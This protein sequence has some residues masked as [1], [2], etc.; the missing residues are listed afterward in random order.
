MCEL[1]KFRTGHCS[2]AI[3]NQIKWIDFVLAQ[4]SAAAPPSPQ[5]AAVAH[6]VLRFYLNQPNY[7]IS[8]L[9]YSSGWYSKYISVALCC[10]RAPFAVQY[11][12]CANLIWWHFICYARSLISFVYFLFLVFV[13][14]P[15]HAHMRSTLCLLYTLARPSIDTHAE[16]SFRWWFWRRAA[17]RKMYSST[18]TSENHKWLEVMC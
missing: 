9:L 15:S 1:W 5:A 2:M 10:P 17:T 18:W 11:G 13:P 7:G 6:L 14:L 8:I 4:G 12:F 16:N 3:T